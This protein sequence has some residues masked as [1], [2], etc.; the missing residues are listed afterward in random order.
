[1]NN[2]LTIHEVSHL[3]NIS[4][5]TLRYW[6]DK[7]IFSIRRADNNYRHYTL[8]DVVEIAEIAFYRRLGIPTRK[9]GNFTQL[10]FNSYSSMLSETSSALEDEIACCQSM[11]AQLKL[12]SQHVKTIEFLKTCSYVRERVPFDRVIPF[13]FE[14]RRQLQRYAET[15]SLYVRVVPSDNLDG[16]IR[17][18]IAGPEEQSIPALWEKKND[19]PFAAFLIEEN[20]SNG[21]TNNIAEKL[22]LIQEK[23]KTGLILANYLFGVTVDGQRIDYLK[24]YAELLDEKN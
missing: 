5:S 7:G 6:Q 11:L 19:R 21:Y 2:Y 12:K 4:E 14:D 20:V 1:M 15:P 13:A 18:I 8:S 17:G 24:G 3:L 16:D 22:A 9:M 23:Y 10:D